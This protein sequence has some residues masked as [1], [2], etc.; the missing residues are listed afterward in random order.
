MEQ[1]PLDGE[2]ACPIVF[3]LLVIGGIVYIDACVDIFVVKASLVA[4]MAA[5]LNGKAVK[6]RN[7]ILPETGS[8]Q[9]ETKQSH[10]RK[11]GG[12]FETTPVLAVSRVIL[13]ELLLHCT[14]V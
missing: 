4:N 9:G 12:G 13:L 1:D 5:N 6:F 14:K 7:F 3:N 2:I 11:C 8:H 10:Q